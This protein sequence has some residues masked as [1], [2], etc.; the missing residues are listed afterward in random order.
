MR[1]QRRRGTGYVCRLSPLVKAKGV[2]IEVPLYPCAPVPRRGTCVAKGEGVR[3]EICY[4]NPWAKAKNRLL[5]PLPLC[6]CT[7]IP[8]CTCTPIPL[9]GTGYVRRQRR[10]GTGYV[11]RQRRRGTGYE[12]IACAF[13]LP[14]WGTQRIAFGCIFDAQ[15]KK[16]KEPMDCLWRKKASKANIFSSIN[17]LIK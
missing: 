2:S 1:R 14:L 7:P 13:S 4:A 10:R 3:G 11:R 5:T 6:T 9:W 16:A 8:L 17:I 12:V 15:Q